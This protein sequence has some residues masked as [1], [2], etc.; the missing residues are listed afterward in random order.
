MTNNLMTSASIEC[1]C[2]I[3]NIQS[4]HIVSGYLT[5]SVK[6]H[7]IHNHLIAFQGEM[8]QAFSNGEY[9][10]VDMRTRIHIVIKMNFCFWNMK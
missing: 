5:I 9:F 8:Q 7:K 6:F 3:S 4:L 1:F 10:M 2:C